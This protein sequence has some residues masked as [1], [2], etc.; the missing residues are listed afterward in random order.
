MASRLLSVAV[1][2]R[3]DY[4][5]GRMRQVFE[6]EAYH[7]GLL[8]GPEVPAAPDFWSF[9]ATDASEIDPVTFRMTNPTMDWLFRA[10]DSVDLD[11]NSIILGRMVIGEVPEGMLFSEL[12]DLLRAVPLPERNREPQ[13]SCVTW[14]VNAVKLLQ[15]R[16]L[17][18]QFDLQTFKDQVLSYGDDRIKKEEALEPSVKYYSA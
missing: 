14:T 17:V 16:S 10:R 5:R 1:Y 8:M 11:T 12:R 7:W 13:Q 4:S 6:Y 18:P 3:G 15:E 9:D 2:D